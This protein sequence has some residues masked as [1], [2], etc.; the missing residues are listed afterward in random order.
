M[1]W[2]NQAA[3]ARAIVNQSDSRITADLRVRGHAGEMV[4]RWHRRVSGESG[5]MYLER[6]FDEE[7]RPIGY[8]RIIGANLLNNPNQEAAY[9]RLPQAF[10]FKDAKQVCGATDGRPN[11]KVAREV[12]ECGTGQAGRAR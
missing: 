2:L 8:R 12:R 6:V 3:G 10:R 5:P 7:G 4:L 1:Q 11:P 9:D